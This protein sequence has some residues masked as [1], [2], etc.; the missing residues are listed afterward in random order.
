MSSTDPASFP[1]RTAP[2]ANRWQALLLLL[3]LFFGFTGPLHAQLRLTEIL[4]ANTGA[5][6]FLDDDGT[7]QGWIEL[8]NSDPA[9]V[10]SLAGY[11]LSNGTTSWSFPAIQIMP[12]ERIVIWASGKNRV[13]V[14]APLHT[15]F[16]LSA[17]GGT[18]SLLNGGS[19]PTDGT[20]ISRFLAYPALAADISWG[21]DEWDTDTVPTQVGRYSTPTPGERNNYTGTGVSGAVTIDTPSQAFTTGL[22]VSLSTPAAT[23][24]QIRYTTDLSVPTPSSTLYTAPIPISATRML[25][26]RAFQPGLLPGA[27]STEAYLLVGTASTFTTTMPLVVVSNF[28][29]SAPSTDKSD[30]AAFLWAWEAPAGGGAIHLTDP[31]TLTSRVKINRRGSSTLGNAK[32]NLSMETRNAYDDDDT[33]VSLLGMPADSDWVLEAPF[34]FDRALVRDPFVYAL[35][36]SIGSYAPRNSMAEVFLEFSGSALT[37]ATDYFGVYNIMEKIRRSKA[38]QNLAKLETYDNS[39]TAKTGGYIWKID[40]ADSSVDQFT[41]GQVSDFVYDYPKG[42]EIKSP[43]RDPQE[44]YLT[45][46]LNALDSAVEAKNHDPLTGYPSMMDVTATIDHHLMNVWTF[47]VD[48][49][50]LSAFWHKD[51]G[52]KVAAGP[53]WDFDRSLFST[54]GRDSNPTV[55]RSTSGDLGTDYFNGATD[56]RRWWHYLF[57]DPDFYQQYI[58]RWQELRQGAFSATNV[59]TLLDTLNGQIP[60]DAVSRDLSRWGMTK[61]SWTSPFTR[62]KYTGQAAEIQRIKDFLQQRA[63]FFDTQWVGPLT[64]S[65]APGRVP[66]G[67]TVALSGPVGATLYYTLDGSDPRPSGGAAPTVGSIVHAYTGPIAVS[68]VTRIRA[69]AYD[70]SHTALTGANNPP[71]VSKWGA[72]SDLSYSDHPLAAAGNVAITEINYQP[73]DP[74]PAELAAKPDLTAYSFEFLELRNTG[75]ETVDLAG[76]QFT[77]GVTYTFP[78]A[79][80]ALAPGGFVVI[81]ADPVALTLRYPSISA[82][83]PWTGDLSNDGET[84]TLSGADASVIS[85]VTYDKSWSSLANGQG[86]DLVV[87]D[88]SAPAATYGTISN[89]RTSAAL[90]GSPG[91]VDPSSKATLPSGITL[92]HYW[93]FNT[94]GTL[95]QP[96]QTIGG[97]ALAVAATGSSVYLADSG[98]NFAG[99]NARNANPVGT[100]LRVNFPLT[101][102]L[103]LAL[104]TNGY[105]GI[106]VRYETRRSGSGAGL[107]TVSYTV[108]GSS[109]QTFATLPIPDGTPMV[110]TL[111]FSSISAAANNPAFA[112][113]ITFQQGAGSTVGNNR[114][115]DL[116]VDGTVIPAINLPPSATG[117]PARRELVVG[118]DDGTVNLATFFTDPEGDA[119]T[120]TAAV[121]PANVASVVSLSG[122]TLQLS[123][124]SQGNATLTLTATD[125]THTPVQ[126]T[127]PLLVGPAPQPLATTDFVFS[128]WDPGQPEGSFPTGIVFLQGAASD[129]VLT[130]PL[131]TAY[132]IPAGDYATVDAANVGFPYRNTSRTRINGLG[133]DGISFINTGRD[134]D[135]GGTLVALDTRQVTTAQVSWTAGTVTANPRIYALRLQAR[136]AITDAFEDIPGSGGGPVEYL[137]AAAGNRQTF[138]PIALPAKFLGQ[139][140]VQLLWRYYQ[141]DGSAGGAR[142]EISLDDIVVTTGSAR[143]Y[144]SWRYSLFAPGDR[145]NDAVSGPAAINPAGG[146]NLLRY[147]LGV[148]PGQPLEPSLPK[149]VSPGGLQFTFDSGKTDIAYRV[150]SS[151]DLATWTTKLFD[152]KLQAWQ[153]YWN[154]STLTIPDLSPPQPG[155]YY[156]LEVE[157]P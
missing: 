143:S 26:A 145:N 41:A 34:D 72:G 127:V 71:L 52:G 129:T 144:A 29:T 98:Q 148:T 57:R 53:T 119:M 156:R 65:V 75:S 40:R 3:V 77:A 13:N 54:D 15:N 60:S 141:V 118:A 46:D 84:V 113:R 4:P 100:H 23:G 31:P 44:Q 82:L 1:L 135:L 128:A 110:E 153:P 86:Y 43:Q 79:T 83:G 35:S 130:T 108:D 109:Y 37:S 95:L 27:T 123:G 103:N 101:A 139:V 90:Q 73:A 154:G 87:Y 61:R 131:T 105:N 142:S 78:P 63:N 89:W 70:A 137:A 96:T 114:F 6:G 25:R 67:T 97:G 138:G 68:G 20:V 74:A 133:L 146:S 11:R 126:A 49:L 125:G 56:S 42:E 91:A 24:V 151:T 33:D 81:A 51:R 121:A 59:N 10:Y 94:S 28:L 134:R 36:N 150:W 32:Y 64:A 136:N 22:T 155:G 99:D 62:V 12:D 152:S 115:D 120:F 85:S 55:W 132:T 5:S 45:Q 116:T 48:G 88:P 140:D 50:R 8:W 93:N 17:S 122:S 7:A 106:V 80:P 92:L 9:N 76:I 2:T 16:T 104:P 30:Q 147:A 21:R 14:Q 157:L 58:D 111:D 19:T 66:V 102:T 107:Q 112:L 47:N 124:L 117:I 39:D 38:R 18:V 69:R 149:F